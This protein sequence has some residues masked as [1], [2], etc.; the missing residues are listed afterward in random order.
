M[1][2]EKTNVEHQNY[3]VDFKIINGI[4]F[5]LFIVLYVRLDGFS[6]NKRQTPVDFKIMELFF[7]F[8]SIIMA[9]VGNFL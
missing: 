6:E 3:Y 2:S 5:F 9:K 8:L 1:G 4:I 7:P